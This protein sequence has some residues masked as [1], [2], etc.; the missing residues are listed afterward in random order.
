MLP[1]LMNGLRGRTKKNPI[2]AGAIVIAMNMLLCNKG[3]K[4]NYTEVRLRKMA[5][6]I[7]TKAL[8]PLIATQK[9]YYCSQDP[10]EIEKQI[11]SLEQRIK[12]QQRSQPGLN[13]EV[14]Y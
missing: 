4:Q 14:F 12:A 9:G 11:S 6:Y 2:L 5:N 13:R 8:L 1:W 3:M 7:R 10:E